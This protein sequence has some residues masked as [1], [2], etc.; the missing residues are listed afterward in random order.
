MSEYL[1]LAF[2][3]I[4]AGNFVLSRFLGICPFLGVS[5][6]LETAMGMSGAV[7]FVMT[8][9]AAVTW[10][11]QNYILVPFRLEA[12]QTLVFILVIATLVQLVEVALRRF[13]PPLYRALGIY[14]PLIT[15]NCAVLGVAVL[16]IKDNNSFL[17]SVV[18]AFAAA[19]G[20]GLALAIFA[21]LRERIDRANPPR[22]FKGVAI[23]LVTAGLLSLAF[24]GFG[25]LAK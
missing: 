25:G 5:K 7:V 9:A 19:V 4:L 15:T 10:L 2:G 18:F 6:R 14:L 1:I 21:G 16:N 23:A 17:K 3:A 20:F 12:L 24:M 8:L 11:I 13:A 22:A